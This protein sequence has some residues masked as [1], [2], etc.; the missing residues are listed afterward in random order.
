MSQ[1][2]ASLAPHTTGNSFSDAYKGTHFQNL[3]TE[4]LQHI[5]RHTFD[6]TDDQ[7]FRNRFEDI[8]LEDAETNR[9]S[10]LR[11]LS[12]FRLIC[13]ASSLAGRAAFITVASRSDDLRSQTLYLPP[14]RGSLGNLL[15]VFDG[16]GLGATVKVVELSMFAR[17]PIIPRKL[18]RYLM[19][20]YPN[21]AGDEISA[22][23]A[24]YR[25]LG[26][27][28]DEY[29]REDTFYSNVQL[30]TAVLDSLPPANRLLVVTV[31]DF[32][33]SPRH[34]GSFDTFTKSERCDE[35]V[36][37]KH[38]PQIFD[39]VNR[40]AFSTVYID[41]DSS[42]FG[43]PF[44]PRVV[45]AYPRIPSVVGVELDVLAQA[46]HTIINLTLN[47]TKYDMIRL[48]KYKDYESYR[49]RH[50]Y[51]N[52]LSRFIKLKS[53]CMTAATHFAVPDYINV[54]W[55]EGILEDQ[56]WPELE[57]F[58]LSFADF[59]PEPIA[60]FLIGHKG[61]LQKV[62]IAYCRCAVSEDE[63]QILQRLPDLLTLRS[64]EIVELHYARSA[65]RA[66]IVFAADD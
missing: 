16:T 17:T 32:L 58:D 1:P 15:K 39:M 4:L 52:F 60:T 53:L 7:S 21:V 59:E 41:A 42:L 2:E 38:L 27:I 36:H 54:T 26:S 47:M 50:A 66:N 37:W 5:A 20:S 45:G 23:A 22:R 61:S 12:N 43:N 33:D 28:A 65:T 19:H 25:I 35:I 34:Y 10:A 57:S 55:L 63:A 13:R 18:M 6:I 14:K 8:V 40:Y 9:V 30:I 31:E 56:L 44:R 51:R 48:C 11:D 24:V 3:P 62:L 29:A 46:C 49:H 64:L